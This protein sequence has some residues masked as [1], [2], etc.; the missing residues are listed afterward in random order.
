MFSE[1]AWVPLLEKEK[2][3]AFSSWDKRSLLT[4][5]CLDCTLLLTS[6]KLESVGDGMLSKLLLHCLQ[7]HEESEFLCLVIRLESLQQ[8]SELMATENKMKFMSCYC[9]YHIR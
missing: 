9:M 4:Y 7:N 3:N 8:S 5:C 2:K 1:T 6:Q